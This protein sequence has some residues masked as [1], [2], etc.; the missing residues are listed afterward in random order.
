MRLAFYTY[1]YLDRLKMPVESTLERIASAGYTGIDVSATFGDSDDPRSVNAARR[2]LLRAT[3]QRLDLRIEAL[4]THAELTTSLVAHDRQPLDLAGTVDLAVDLAAEVVTFHMGGVPNGVDRAKLWRQVVSSVREAADYGAARHVN[5]AVDGIWPTWLVDSPD[6]LAKMFGEVGHENFGVNLDPSYLTLMGVD[7]AAFCRRFSDR[8]VHAHLK[9]HAGSYPK[10]KHHIPG[11]GEM[12]Y[13]PVLQAM[14]EIGF[15]HA[16][17]VEC[18]TDMKFE[19]A[20]EETV[21][22]RCGKQRRRRESV[23]RDELR[24]DRRWTQSAKR[25]VFSSDRERILKRTERAMVFD[26]LRRRRWARI[27]SEPFPDAWEEILRQNVWHYA[28]LSEAEQAKLRQDIQVLVAE[29]NWEGCGGLEMTDEV[30]VTIAGLAALLVLGMEEEYYGKLHSVLVYPGAYVA[31]ERDQFDSGSVVFEGGEAREGE[32][33]Y[34]GPVILSWKEVLAGGQRRGGGS[35]VVLHE[36]AHQLDMMNGREVDGAPELKT[37]A[38]RREW[39]ATM[40][41]AYEQ[42]LAD[43]RQ[44]RPTV[45]DCYG[46]E[47]A[48]EFFAVATEGFFERAAAV[49]EHLPRL[50]RTLAAYYRQDPAARES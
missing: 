13:A 25:V 1:S 39:Q 3:A 23:G 30:R 10:W 35:S 4:V 20:C 48:A 14:Q 19:E 26:W 31:Q 42:L 41:E 50:Y 40:T 33:W 7:P 22:W 47:D 5:V 9:D 18:F 37:A 16:A 17:A 21:T 24:S 27:R 44:R 28:A 36:F 46:C 15:D 34:R 2:R 8:I 6:R 43:C 11:A 12:D 29:K 32:A 45:L 49:R 38:A